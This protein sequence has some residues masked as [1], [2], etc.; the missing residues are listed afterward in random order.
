YS[1]TSSTNDVSTAYG[2]SNPSGQNS[3]YEHASSYSLH[4]NQSSCPQ[5]DHDEF[6]LEEMDLK[7]QIQE[8]SD[9]RRRDTWYNGNKDKENRRRSGKQEDSKALVT[10]DGEGV[11]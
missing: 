10:L 6:D 7:W 1:T 4:A 5:L 8:E 11:D 3:Q 9:N 2:V